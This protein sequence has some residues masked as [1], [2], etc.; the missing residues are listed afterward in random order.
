MRFLFVHQNCPGQYVHYLRHLLARGGHEVFFLTAPNSNEIPGLRK[1]NYLPQGASTPGIHPDAVDFESGMIRARSAHDRALQ[2]AGM[3]MRPDVIIG[4]NGWGEMLHMRD[5]WPQTPSIAYFEF[6]YQSHGLDVDFDPEFPMAPE[7]R[8]QVRVKNAI[9]LLGLEATTIGQTPTYFQ[10]GTYPAWAQDKIEMIPEGAALEMFRPD[11]AASFALP[12]ARRR[13]RAS[14]GRRLLTFVARNLEP[15]RGFHVM[16][17]ALPAI[18]AATPDLDVV[19]VGSDGVSY[20]AACP[21][22]SWKAH[23]LAEVGP[24]LDLRRV[25]FAGHLEYGEYRRLLQVSAAH[26]YLTYPFVASWSLRE[27]LAT[28]CAIIGSDTEPVREFITHE[29]NGLLV[30]FHDA[31]ALAEAVTRMLADAALAERLRAAARDFA[32]AHLDLAQHLAAMDGLVA[33]V[34]GMQP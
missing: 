24:R 20:G 6:F 17:R 14:S 8:A 25:F 22:G 2:L 11:R 4:H 5:I 1:V 23:F 31:A 3:G 15:Y 34:T 33:R 30:P 32:A 9:N 18:L 27:A 19:L 12:A 29:R 13:W 10:R 26:V 16:L 7:K 28:G 21:S